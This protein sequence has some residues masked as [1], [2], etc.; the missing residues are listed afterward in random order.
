M[1][2]DGLPAPRSH[3]SHKLRSAP[4]SPCPIGSTMTTPTVPPIPPDPGRLRP[5]DGTRFAD[6]PVSF[7]L[8]SR[9]A[10]EPAMVMAWLVRAMSERED[11]GLGLPPREPSTLA[12]TAGMSVD[13]LSQCTELLI[14]DAYLSRWPDGSIHVPWGRIYQDSVEAAWQLRRHVDALRAAQDHAD[15]PRAM[16]PLQ[17]SLDL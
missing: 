5:P 4:V 14:R 1:L 2:R 12:A 6:I 10:G 15:P 16:A 17:T 3:H 9:Y 7:L 8:L 13:E 11:A